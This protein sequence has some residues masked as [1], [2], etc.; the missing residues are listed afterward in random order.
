MTEKMTPILKWQYEQLLKEMLLL[1]NHLTDQDCPCETESEMCVRK[2]LLIIE[3]YAQ[4]TIPLETEQEF[5]TKLQ[6]LAVEAKE[7]RNAEERM[8]RGEDLGLT[9]DDSEWVR[10]W[11]KEFEPRSLSKPEGT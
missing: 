10:R 5:Q 6:Q 9:K 4:E 1:Q 7:K 3:A 11:R 2:H 8:L